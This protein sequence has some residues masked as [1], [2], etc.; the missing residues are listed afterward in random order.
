MASISEAPVVLMLT[1]LAID[2][3]YGWPDALYRWIRHPVV[4]IGTMIH[5]LEKTL[6]RSD[7]GRVWRLVAGAF[8]TT[9]VVVVSAGVASLLMHLLPDSFSGFTLVALITASLFAS[10]SL[11]THVN[12]VAVPLGQGELVAARAA[13]SMIVGRNTATLD[14]AGIARASLESLAENASDGVIAPLFWGSLLGLPG[15]AA[16]KA[17]N[18]LDSMIGHRAPRY[19]EFGTV[20]AR[21]DDLLNWVPARITAVLFAVVSGNVNAWS[22]SGRDARKHR[23]PNAG[24][25]EASMA[26][27]LGVRLSGPRC[28]VA[29]QSDDPWLNAQARDPQ[30]HDIKRG[31]RLYRHSLWLVAGQLLVLLLF[32]WSK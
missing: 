7:K 5:W 27:A 15:M 20:A 9:I 19:A 6:N 12:A 8:T 32:Q 30:V 17:V 23:S 28:Y 10:R 24:W 16:Y 22:V 2:A 21:L 13:V 11:H 3:I 31:L 4:W 29:S 26:G 14:S 18:T 25:P 1:A